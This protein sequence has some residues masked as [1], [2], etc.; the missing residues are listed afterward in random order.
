MARIEGRA[1]GYINILK[2]YLTNGEESGYIGGNGGIYFDYVVPKDEYVSQVTFKTSM[3]LDSITF[4]TNKGKVFKIG[5]DGGNMISSVEIL[6]GTHIV[7]F[8][9]T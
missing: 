5:G 4:T 7:G 2:F 9:G 8:Y 6:E 1:D 3:W